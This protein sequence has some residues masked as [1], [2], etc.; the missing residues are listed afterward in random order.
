MLSTHEQ[1]LHSASEDDDDE[2]VSKVF[3]NVRELHALPMIPTDY[4]ISIMPCRAMMCCVMPCH[5]LSYPSIYLPFY[6][7][8]RQ[9]ISCLVLSYPI[10]AYTCVDMPALLSY[11]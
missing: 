3:Y 10:L 4:A 8:F 11:L 7:L 9:V 5:V 1:R 6:I 2:A